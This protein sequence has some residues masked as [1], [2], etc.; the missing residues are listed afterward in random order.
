MTG[1]EVMTDITAIFD[2]GTTSDGW[3]IGI[4]ESVAEY[5]AARGH[6]VTNYIEIDWTDADEDQRQ[7]DVGDAHTETGREQI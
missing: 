2:A 7:V 5:L 6:H 3:D 1:E 4:L